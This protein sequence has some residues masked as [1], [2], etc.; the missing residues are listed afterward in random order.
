MYLATPMKKVLLLAAIVL[1]VSF[2]GSRVPEA[3]RFRAMDPGVRGGDPG[4]GGPIVGVN[5]N[6]TGAL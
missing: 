5:A 3:Q 4:A 1:I 2:L 6:G